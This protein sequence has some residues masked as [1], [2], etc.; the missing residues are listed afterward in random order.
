MKLLQRSR[1][2]F[3]IYTGLV[4]ALAV[5]VFYLVLERQ[6]LEDIDDDLFIQKQKVVDGLNSSALDPQELM[7]TIARINSLN[8]GVMIGPLLTDSVVRP[9]FT[10]EI[11]HDA[12]HDH[13]EPFRTLLAQATIQG[14][15]YVIRIERVIE[16][17]EELVLAI[18][19][20]IGVVLVLLFGGVMIL[21]RLAAKRI[22]APFQETLKGIKSFQVDSGEPFRA[23]A[24]GVVEFDELER[25]VEQLAERNTSIYAEQ[26]RFTENAAHEMRTPVALLQSKVDRLFQSPDLSK[27]QAILLEEANIILGR[28]R[29]LYD[30]LVQLASIDNDNAPAQGEVRP[31]KIVSNTLALLD[32]FINDHGI[33]VTVLDK[34]TDAWRIAPSLAEVLFANLVRNAIAHNRDQGTVGIVIT[35]TSFEIGN[36]GNEK[37]L[38]DSR[39]FRRF[40]G[41]GKGLGL[42][43][44]IAA[45]VCERR[46]W[47]V[48]YA[49]HN[50]LHTFVIHTDS[51]L[52]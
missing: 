46:G 44:A 15:T 52:A 9:V 32:P 18:S 40:A 39:L 12:Y 51:A 38:D 14:Q 36:T 50:G 16:E 35:D 1:R 8:A 48:K 37:A 49:F 5:P 23:R 22:W 43:L 33:S 19:M 13:D 17:T 41:T 34:S 21:D 42:G 29:K 47:S 31:M 20:V 3:W 27:D 2:P 11:R 6:L 24:T 25:A 45:Q 10:T 28:M 7:V 30:G 4:L 26:R